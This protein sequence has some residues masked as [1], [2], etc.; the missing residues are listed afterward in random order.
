M[1]TS[2]LFPSEIT[3]QEDGNHEEPSGFK[4]LNLDQV[5]DHLFDRNKEY[6]LNRYFYTPL[7]DYASVNYRQEVFKDLDQAENKEVFEA[8]FSEIYWLSKYQEKIEAILKKPDDFENNYLAKGRMLDYADRYGQA[9]SK[10]QKE[11]KKLTLNSEGLKEFI[12]YLNEYTSTD[13]FINLEKQIAKLR[14][15][16]AE[17]YYCMLISGGKIKVR[18]YNNEEDYSV[19]ILR[20]FAKF[21]QGEV[22]DYRHRFSEDPYAEHVEAMVLDLVSKLYPEIFKDLV[23]FCKNNQGFFDPKIIRFNREI[24]F[25][26]SWQQF[27]EPLQQQGLSFTYP[28]MKEE[29]KDNYDLNGFDLALAL[30]IGNQIVTNDWELKD[31]ER[32]LV[33][34]G[35]NQ[36]GKTTFARYFGQV[37][38]LASLG[39][40][41][42]GTKAQ[43]SLCDNVY[44]HF[45]KEEDLN[46][47]NGKLQDDLIRLKDLLS[48]VT[49]NS[50]IV[51]NEIFASTTLE[52]ALSLGKMMMEKLS[53][54]HTKGV[55][56]TF[57]DELAT[58]SEMTVSMMSLMDADQNKRTYKVKRK[59]PDGLAY[60][61]SLAQK[62]GLTYQQIVERLKK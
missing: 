29:L 28:T 58:Y 10:L 11:A 56:V 17:V 19:E 42:P 2:I 47:L 49:P 48:K 21:R 31:P 61:L 62:Y 24:P 51:I 55:I 39:L 5:F 27:I 8:F 43:L 6:S 54:S 40:S 20:S 50:V 25:Y 7:K 23:L 41:V 59:E 36:G 38:Y 33:V 35:P 57:L 44:T 46:S 60:A 9:V 3:T 30:S 22:K 12:N 26:F 32:F 53:N 14:N 16:L 34:S 52:D 45:S 1:F 18:K 4:D 15:E 37:N 13:N